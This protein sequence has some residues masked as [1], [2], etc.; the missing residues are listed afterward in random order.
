[1]LS[2]LLTLYLAALLF[3]A[4]SS[5]RHQETDRGFL[6]A[7]RSL[8]TWGVAASATVGV[9]DS[10][11]ILIMFGSVLLFGPGGIGIWF[12]YF[13][14]TVCLAL[15]APRFYDHVQTYDLHTLSEFFRFRLGPNTERIFLVVVTLFSIGLIIGIYSINL[16][17]FEHFLGL[18][19]VSA[20]IVSFLVTLSYV[21]LG[22]FRALVRTDILQFAIVLSLIAILIWFIPGTER[23][24]AGTIPDWFSG[25]FWAIAPVIFFQNMIKPAAWQPILG[26]RSRATA[27][28]GMWLAVLCNFLIIIP[29]VY[30]S[31]AF[32]AT[33]P[34]A[35]P[36]QVLLDAIGPVLPELAG[37]LV[38]ILLFAALMSSLD[39]I[40]F[41]VASNLVRYSYPYLALK[42]LTQIGLTRIAIAF[43]ALTTSLLAI[44]VP[45]FV[46]FGF[47]IVPLVGIMAI[48]FLA[49]MFYDFTAID[50]IVTFS[51]IVSLL[52]FIYLFVFPPANYLWNI[53]P[54]LLCG[55]SLLTYL[56]LPDKKTDQTGN[57]RSN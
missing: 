42:Y 33:L 18:G 3:I 6:V 13:I 45:D 40:I 32:A 39:S 8:S 41:F 27:R 54:I 1:M 55:A 50:S 38:F 11:A 21:L 17:I 34:T 48:P 7:N 15:L 47:A 36:D 56:L 10:T 57:K 43:V 29:A 52:V 26:A 46:T 22:G 49:A 19:V 16:V 30:V 53:L 2:T 25:A 9:I 37:P 14:A 31:F 5:Y 4:R 24:S 44:L 28:S 51:C 23:V 12:G 20:T 35:A